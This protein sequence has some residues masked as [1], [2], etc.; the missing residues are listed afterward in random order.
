MYELGLKTNAF[1]GSAALGTALH[2]TLAQVYQD[3]HCLD[4]L[5]KL[6]WLHDCWQQHSSG[7]NLAQAE[8]GKQILE[9]YYQNFIVPEVALRRPLAI[10]GKIQG[11]LQVADLEFAIALSL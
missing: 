4:P 9:T 1:F 7:L 11:R 3:W 10:E 6:D 8:E 5:P 2:Q